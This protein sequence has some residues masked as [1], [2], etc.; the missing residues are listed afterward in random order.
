[1]WY[2]DLARLVPALLGIRDLVFNLNGTRPCFDHFLSEQVSCFFI[3]ETGINVGNDW[4]D[5]GL[6]TVDTA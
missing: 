6:K 4:H 3:T 2:R 1:M 5:V